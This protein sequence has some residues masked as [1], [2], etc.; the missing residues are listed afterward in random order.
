ME[1]VRDG[2]QEMMALADDAGAF[3]LPFLHFKTGGFPPVE[4][5]KQA[6]PKFARRIFA[7]LSA[8]IAD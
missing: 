2:G 8:M 4:A 5:A 6:A 3:D 1:M 7:R